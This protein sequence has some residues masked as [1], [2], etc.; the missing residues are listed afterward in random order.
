MAFMFGILGDTILDAQGVESLANM[1]SKEMLIAQ[2]LGL[3]QSGAR[4]I[5]SVVSA[6]P[7]NLAVVIGARA[8]QLG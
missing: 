1:P 7:R 4:G 8:K 5:A 6:V 2:L 3:L